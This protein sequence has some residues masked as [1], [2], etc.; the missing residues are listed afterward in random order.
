MSRSADTKACEDEDLR[1]AEPRAVLAEIARRDGFH[2]LPL[3]V[4]VGL[5]DFGHAGSEW[6]FLRV[7]LRRDR[8]TVGVVAGARAMRHTAW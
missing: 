7:E 8:D 6:P 3:G 2:E 4:R 1:H 5:L